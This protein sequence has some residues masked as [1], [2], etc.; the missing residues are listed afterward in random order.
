MQRREFLK[1][2]AITAATAA[3]ATQVHASSRTPVNPIAKRTL[4]KVHRRRPVTALLSTPA[5]P[6]N[7]ITDLIRR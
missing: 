6:D 3:A 7:C 2:A 1:Q 5:R 4:G